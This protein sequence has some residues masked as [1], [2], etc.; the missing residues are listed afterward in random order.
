[1]SDMVG[2]MS[3]DDPYCKLKVGKKTQRTT[4]KMNTLSPKWGETFEFEAESTDELIVTVRDNIAIGTP[5]Y[6][7]YCFGEIIIPLLK[8]N[9]GE[10]YEE[11]LP[12][13]KRRGNNFESS[14]SV[15]LNLI[16]T[17]NLE[18]KEIAES[19]SE[20]GELQ[21]EKI[22]LASEKQTELN[23]EGSHHSL[24]IPPRRN[25]ASSS[26]THSPPT[27]FRRNSMAVDDTSMTVLDPHPHLRFPSEGD[28]LQKQL[29]L[30]LKL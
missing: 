22:K 16:L 10:E 11:W 29:I 3:T 18:A 26:V 19:E 30:F 6:K 28:L 24:P 9:K 7:G 4:T 8:L 20:K 2:G 5:L 1:M 13:N 14:G 12:L 25:S 17:P 15:L 27:E 23:R 21:I